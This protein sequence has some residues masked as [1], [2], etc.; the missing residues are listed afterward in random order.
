MVGLSTGSG[1]VDELMLDGWIDAMESSSAAKEMLPQVVTH[2][3]TEE[4][5]GDRLTW[6]V[7]STS[8]GSESGAQVDE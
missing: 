3:C 1:S 7:T 2:G 4:T 8:G 6:S 5:G